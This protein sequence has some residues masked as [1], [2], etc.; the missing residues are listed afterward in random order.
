MA[1]PA[2]EPVKFTEQLP[3]LSVQLLVLR[4]PAEPPAVKLTV[5]IGVLV[6]P[7]EV[8]VTVAVQSV[9]ALMGTD[10]GK[11]LTTMVVVL[12]LTV[13]VVVLELMA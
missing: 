10:V 8:S 9:G 6:A 2:A 4:E 1:A 13:T 7:G 3:E 5:L 12:L 11:Q